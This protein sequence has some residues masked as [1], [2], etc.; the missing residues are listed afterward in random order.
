[1]VIARPL[2]SFVRLIPAAL[3]ALVYSAPAV[4]ADDWLWPE[5]ARLSCLASARATLDVYMDS[6][7]E[8]AGSHVRSQCAQNVQSDGPSAVVTADLRFVKRFRI[9]PDMALRVEFRHWEWQR[10][11]HLARI[12]SFARGDAACRRLFRGE[13]RF[14]LAPRPGG[15]G[16]SRHDA[17][18]ERVDGA[19][20]GAV[21]DDMW[22][23]AIAD[24]PAVINV[25]TGRIW[26][27]ERSLPGVSD[28][29]AGRPAIRHRIE[30]EVKGML[31]WA[32]RF[33]RI[34]WFSLDGEILRVC[35]FQE[36]FGLTH[37]S[38]FV[39]SELGV[40]PGRDCAHWF[41]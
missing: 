5:E 28:T 8:R 32:A 1:M 30:S 38:E 24:A 39:R 3:A 16:L 34:L 35:D 9:L 33:A 31:F 40:V 4:G 17:D 19:P 14:E 2:P 36:D 22:S 15:W 12:L 29:I 37:V 13:C 41:E 20:P 6:S 18:G 23:P 7:D 21:L 10:E 26:R 11:A 25:Y 27:I